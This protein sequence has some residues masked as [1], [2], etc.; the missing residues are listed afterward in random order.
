MLLK[1]QRERA[2]QGIGTG[3]DQVGRYLYGPPRNL[4]RL[5]L[6]SP[7][8]RPRSPGVTSILRWRDGDFR[9]RFA[10][11]K[12]HSGTARR[13]A[14]I[15]DEKVEGGPHRRGACARPSC[16]SPRAASRDQQLSKNSS[17]WR[18]R[19]RLFER[20]DPRRLGLARPR[21]GGRWGTNV[22][23]SARHSARSP[24]DRGHPSARS[25][26]RWTT[27]ARALQQQPIMAAPSWARPETAVWDADRVM[28]G[29]PLG[30]PPPSFVS[31]CVKLHPHHRGPCRCGP[32]EPLDRA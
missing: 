22:R 26:C 30:A 8:A 15:V 7:S 16:E 4:R 3:T 25:S 27:A 11:K 2:P 28:A 12:L 29:K 32:C 6:Q 10:A 1:P 13:F 31:A 17:R 18:A 24:R 5:R 14:G 21:S 20:R 19:L 9:A 23:D